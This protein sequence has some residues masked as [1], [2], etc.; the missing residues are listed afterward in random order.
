MSAGPLRLAEPRL[1][2]AAGRVDSSVLQVLGALTVEH[3]IY[4]VRSQRGGAPQVVHRDSAAGA[5][6]A[7]EITT[8]AAGERTAAAVT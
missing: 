8:D 5:R 2:L 3:D 1:A 4:E 6:P 7:V